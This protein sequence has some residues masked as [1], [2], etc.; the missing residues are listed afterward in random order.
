MSTLRDG[1][2]HLPSPAGVNLAVDMQALESVLAARATAMG[3]EIRRG[4][5][6]EDFDQTGE[7]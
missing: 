6:V 5:G 1:R 3:A 4:V 7:A 2:Y